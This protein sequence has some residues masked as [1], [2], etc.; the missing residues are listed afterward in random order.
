MI[1]Y[2]V[3]IC[4]YLIKL[5]GGEDFVC[6]LFYVVQWLLGDWVWVM[7][8]EGGECYVGL[9]DCFGCWFFKFCFLCG[10]VLVLLQVV[11]GGWGE[12]VLEGVLMLNYLVCLVL[13]FDFEM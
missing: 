1:G 4:C 9:G 8:I 7:L 6:M 13:C 3:W 12:G 5:L 10:V 11:S 2:I